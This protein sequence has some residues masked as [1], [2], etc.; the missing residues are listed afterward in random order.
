[1]C[2]LESHTWP[3][4]IFARWRS[5][6]QVSLLRVGVV[7]WH[8]SRCWSV[9]FWLQERR[10]VLE[11][12]PQECGSS[13]VS[14][15]WPFLISDI[16]ALS[17]SVCTWVEGFPV[18]CNTNK[19][20]FPPSPPGLGVLVLTWTILSFFQVLC[21]L[22]FFHPSSYMR[23]HLDFTTSTISKLVH[24]DVVSALRKNQLCVS[25]SSL[26]KDIQGYAGKWLTRPP[27]IHGKEESYSPTEWASLSHVCFVLGLVGVLLFCFGFL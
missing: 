6:L 12:I 11:E 13:S 19:T 8:L 16:T 24:D 25:P 7:P 26:S 1:M 23:L 14:V 27:L 5:V 15:H 18:R 22:A 21:T 20:W 2:S 9:Y 10:H 17:Q 3:C 4:R